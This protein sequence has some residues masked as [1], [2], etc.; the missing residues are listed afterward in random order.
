MVSP[1][2]PLAVPRL[3]SSTSRW[4]LACLTLTVACFDQ[5]REIPTLLLECQDGRVIAYIVSGTPEE[6]ATGVFQTDAVEVRL[7]SAPQC[8]ESDP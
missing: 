2:T 7:D 6:I 3:L 4:L 5:S 1:E 8:F